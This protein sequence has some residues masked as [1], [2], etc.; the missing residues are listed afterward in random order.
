MTRKDPTVAD[1]YKALQPAPQR[2]AF[3]LAGVRP[4]YASAGGK[5]YH[6]TINGYRR[7]RIFEFPAIDFRPDGDEPHHII[8]ASPSVQA[9]ITIDVVNY[10]MNSPSS[11]HYAI[12]P[13]LRHDVAE[14]DEKIKSQLQGRVPVFV[15]VEEF[16][17][18]TPVEMVRGE[19]YVCDETY[20]L[21]GEL[22]PRLIGGREGEEFLTACPTIDGAWP[23]VPN[24]Q[25]LV[26][27]ILA[28]IRAGQRTPDPIRKYVDQSCLV[29]DD[30]RFV[31]M[32]QLTMS[33]RG[34]AATVMDTAAYRDRASEI[35]RAITAMEKAIETPH[36][37]LLVN[38]MYSDEYKDDAYQ[39]LEYLSLHQSL[40]DSGKKSLG[41]KGN[42]TKDEKIVDGGHTLR[43]LNKYRNAVAHWWTNAID[44]N[45]LADLRRTVNELIRRK[46]FQSHDQTGT[47]SGSLSEICDR[48]DV[49]QS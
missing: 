10:F 28:C 19:C 44:E 47:I 45:F 12:S 4:M 7:T 9:C 21:D 38:S 20:I 41:Y 31:L 14:T 36:L 18:L 13:S 23:E 8:Y 46:Y 30:G 2:A 39:R 32:M 1:R 27:M 16:N 22:V 3:P 17:Q 40:A 34:S 37:A 35:K 11:T 24:N 42:I 43:E 49:R 25:Q 6:C 5:E 26:N 33:A 29:T 15:V 48:H